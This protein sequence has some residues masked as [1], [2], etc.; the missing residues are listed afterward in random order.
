[1]TEEIIQLIHQI[2][3]AQTCAITFARTDLEDIDITLPVSGLLNSHI[4]F[5]NTGSGKS[6]TLA[7]LYKHGYA[8]LSEMLKESFQSKCGLYCLIS[9]VNM[10]PM[11]CITSEKIVYNL[12]IYNDQGI[13]SL[14][15]KVY[16]L[17]MRS[18]LSLLMQ[19]KTR[20]HF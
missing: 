13:K 6:N 15:R 2:V 17:N 18:F 12:S 9:M 3:R 10:V 4:Y 14:C 11:I 7:S 5:R 20:N 8:A 16:Y 19:H 1:V